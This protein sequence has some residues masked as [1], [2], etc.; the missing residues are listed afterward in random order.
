MAASWFGSNLRA[1]PN[2][3]W[4]CNLAPRLDA[5]TGQPTLLQTGQTS[6]TMRNIGYINSL[7]IASY[8][9]SSGTVTQIR[10]RSG[11][12][13]AP[14]KFTVLQCS[15]GLCGTAKFLSRTIRPR[16]NAVTTVALNVKV[17]RTLDSI[18]TQVID[19]VALSA[20]GP[21]TLPLRDQETAGTFTSGSALTQLWYPLT[22]IGE[23]R[24]EGDAADGL[25]LLMQWTFVP[26]R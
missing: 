15:S 6:C 18:N 25:E 9:P 10:I 5:I 23:P 13:P 17:L 11:A 26:R 16:A 1:A 14:L 8:V 3:S 19:A 20:V 4:G 22:T 12:N 24:V 21:G 2:A 7:Q